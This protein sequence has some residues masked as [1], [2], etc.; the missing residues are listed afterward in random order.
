MSRAGS[1][2]LPPGF[3]AYRDP[4][5]RRSAQVVQGPPHHA[6]LMRSQ[7]HDMATSHGISPHHGSHSPHH[8]SHTQLHGSQNGIHPQPHPQM[9]LGRPQMTVGYPQMTGGHAMLNGGQGQ[10]SGGHP[11][12]SGGQQVH[13]GQG[14]VSGGHP[15]VIRGPQVNGGLPPPESSQNRALREAFRKERKIE[16]YLADDLNF[17]CFAKKL[18]ENDL[19]LRDIPAD[20]NCLFRALG[21]QLEGHCR[22]HYRH[23]QEIVQYMLDHR[24]DFEPFVEDDVPFD[25]HINKLKKLGTHAGNDAIVAFARLHN[26]NVFIHQLR[27]DPLQISGPSSSASVRQIHIAYHNGDHY[28]SLRRDGDNT[29]SPANI[30]IQD[31]S[32]TP[33][34]V[35]P[36]PVPS[37]DDRGV[38]TAP[39][40]PVPSL[41]DRGVV[42]APPPPVPSLDDLGMV[43]VKRDLS[44]L[45]AE[46]TRATG[47]Q[48][49]R[50][51]RDT[52]KKNSYDVDATIACLLQSLEL[53]GT[54]Q[55]G[56]ETT[57][58]TSQQTTDSG[59]WPA[60]GTSSLIMGGGASG[61]NSVKG[62]GQKV[63]F[64]E[65]SYGGSSGYSSMGSNRGGG[66]RPKLLIPST[67]VQYHI[68]TG[69][70]AKELKKLE[71]KRRL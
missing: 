59:I 30:K 63:H 48:D 10:V 19:Q 17:P 51:V 69:H 50:T 34:P 46:V 52:L 71:K 42:T 67:P 56:D 15:Q 65:D 44:H 5:L 58:L 13:G 33:A 7:R 49:A 6:T 9:T 32:L 70:R 24:K 3:V 2:H 41:D 39:P 8:G 4:T 22:N 45:E 29:E 12:V 68:V 31:C 25:I 36:P 26:V 1:H 28:S 55:A 35:P 21:D 27:G 20:G 43:T 53:R 57:S 37:L 18:K 16:S 61:R 60:N 54:T 47:C 14:Q 66:T 11:Q 38:V 23:R 40:P 62:K 64:R